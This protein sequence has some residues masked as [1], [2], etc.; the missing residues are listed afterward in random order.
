MQVAQIDVGRAGELAVGDEPAGIGLAGS[1]PPVLVVLA[2]QLVRVLGPQGAKRQPALGRGAAPGQVRCVPRGQVRLAGAVPPVLVLGTQPVPGAAPVTAALHAA[3]SQRPAAAGRRAGIGEEL[4]QVGAPALPPPDDV[5]VAQSPLGRRAVA[6]SDRA[7]GG[8]EDRVV[9]GGDVDLGAEFRP[10]N[11]HQLLQQPRP[12]R[13]LPRGSHSRTSRPVNQP[14]ASS[15]WR[16]SSTVRCP[17]VS[18]V[19]VIEAC[20]RHSFTVSIPAPRRSSQVA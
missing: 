8:G 5:S 1:P 9:R 7:L 16:A 6:A 4:L 3:G 10:D 17:Y 14:A 12:A 19:V 11:G 2:E 13:R 15:V 20:P 18:I